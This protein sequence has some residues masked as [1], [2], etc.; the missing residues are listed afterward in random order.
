MIRTLFLVVLFTAAF[1]LTACDPSPNITYDNQTEHL[2][3]PYPSDEGPPIPSSAYCDEV[4]PNERQ[5]YGTTVCSGDDP[6]WITLAVGQGGRAIYSGFA[7]CGDWDGATVTIRQEGDE[8]V[9]TDD[10]PE[11]TPIQ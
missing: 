1:L 8:F 6:L 4:E 11:G 10:L 9:V 2:L 3:C 5:S 7:T